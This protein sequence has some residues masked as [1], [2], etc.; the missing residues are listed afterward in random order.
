MDKKI[1]NGLLIVLML[2]LMCSPILAVDIKRSVNEGDDNID[3]N[4]SDN[5]KKGKGYNFYIDLLLFSG[6]LLMPMLVI[7]IGFIVFY[8]YHTRRIKCVFITKNLD[9]LIKN[10]KPSDEGDIIFN[11]KMYQ[12]SNE[13]KRFFSGW[14]FRK[15]IF[16]WKVG[17]S[18]PLDFDLVANK[19]DKE[20]ASYYHDLQEKKI[21]IQLLR[22]LSQTADKTGG[23]IIMLLIVLIGVIAIMFLVQQGYIKI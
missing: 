15:P 21:W 22:L 7:L 19:D 9:V 13:K 8:T 5:V 12:T 20:L 10:I 14:M 4:N 18:T 11:K 23:I 17:V 1:I 2:V 6:I 3:L 16:L